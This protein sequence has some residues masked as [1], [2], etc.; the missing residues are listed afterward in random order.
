MSLFDELPDA[1][2]KIPGME[3]FVERFWDA[4]ELDD[5]QRTLLD[6]PF[7]ENGAA[8]LAYGISQT[9]SEQP[10]LRACIENLL[11]F[12][13]RGAQA[14]LGQSGLPFWWQTL[15]GKPG[16]SCPDCEERIALGVGGGFALVLLLSPEPEPE[17][18]GEDPLEA[19]QYAALEEALVPEEFWPLDPENFG[20]LVG[21]TALRSGIPYQQ[22]S[23]MAKSMIDSE[24]GLQI[25]SDACEVAENSPPSYR[26]AQSA[27][28][29]ASR[30]PPG[31]VEGLAAQLGIAPDDIQIIDI[32]EGDGEGPTAV[33]M[34]V[35]KKGFQA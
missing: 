14:T 35:K 32:S 18:A 24:I 2:R 5:H 15:R 13:M 25:V 16:C 4:Q 26:E 7:T 30:L 23:P 21:A 34:G 31:F 9:P 8:Q 20:R 19:R 17:I 6:L 27:D 12:V 10:I 1:V 28:E 29:M 11:V 33:S 22:L 3:L